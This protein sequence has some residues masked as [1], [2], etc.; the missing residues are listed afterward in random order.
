MGVVLHFF[1][2]N[3]AGVNDAGDVVDGD[4]AACVAF[5]NFVLTEIEMFD[6]FCGERSRPVHT[7]LVVVV[8]DCGG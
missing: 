2:V 8:N 6:A 3:V 5:A 1:R 4:I 7:G